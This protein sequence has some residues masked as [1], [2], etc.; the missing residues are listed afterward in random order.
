[1]RL[2]INLAS[3]PYE[4]ARQF[5]MR[6]GTAVGALGLLTVVLVGMTITGW[7][8]ARHDHAAIAQVRQQIANRDAFHAEAETILNSPDH[9]T[10]RD[11]SQFLNE[12][13]DRKSFS[14][15]Q[16]L[17]S[18]EKVM[19]PRVHLVNITP[20]SDEENQISLKM[21]VAGESRD[22]VLELMRRM[23]ESQRFAHTNI[24]AEIFSPTG[25]DPE[26]AEI[27]ALY[28]PEPP[29]EMAKSQSDDKAKSDSAKADSAKSGT[30]GD[31]KPAGSKSSKNPAKPM[32][33]VSTPPPVKR[34]E[35]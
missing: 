16:V 3:Q 34:N 2:D 8:N 18:M 14:W 5:W 23:E 30:F 4:D 11:E 6:W 25:A 26:K 35:H 17:E 22:R 33:G 31:A 32:T 12:L 28:I 19:P 20:A 9:R 15:T 10:T 1:M 24:N 27:V 7:A 29:S 21:T 13:I